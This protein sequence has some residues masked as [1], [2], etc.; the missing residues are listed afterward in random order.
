[1][2]KIKTFR[3]FVP[4]YVEVDIEARNR[5]SAIR[6]AKELHGVKLNAQRV[7]RVFGHQVH[8]AAISE[9]DVDGTNVK[10]L[11]QAGRNDQIKI[12]E[13]TTVFVED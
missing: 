9:F 6:K 7:L 10:E 4:A 3:I 8:D 1:M 13:Q 12:N 5:A 11:D 2:A